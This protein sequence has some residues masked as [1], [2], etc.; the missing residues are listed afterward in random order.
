MTRIAG[1]PQQ[2]EMFSSTLAEVGVELSVAAVSV[3][4]AG[5]PAM[6]PGVAGQVIE[7]L[8]HTGTALQRAAVTAEREAAEVRRRALW[9]LAADRGSTTALDAAFALRAGEMP[10]NVL[11]LLARRRVTQMLA[12]WG[13][14]TRVVLPVVREYGPTSMPATSIWFSWQG[15]NPMPLSRLNSV[16]RGAGDAAS[17]ERASG[18]PLVGLRAVAGKV[19]GPLG[20]A[21]S[22]YS[23]AY[24]EH[25]TGWERTGDQ[26]AAGAGMLGSGGMTALA[27]A[28]E[29][30]AVPGVNIA[31]G[32]LLVGA[33][34]WEIYTHRKA[35]A[36]AA[37]SAADFAWKHRTAVLA[38]TPAGPAL[39]AWDHR[40]DI[41][42]G[43]VAATKW[44]GDRLSDVGHG[45]ASAPGEIAHDFESVTNGIHF[46]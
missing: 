36:H 30:A 13:R 10:L 31:V 27:F 14:Y 15:R 25:S 44:S 12:A 22:I 19:L 46:P 38:G 1:I 42:R 9:L 43:A 8:A 26:V 24:P 39:V 16:I 33:A 37:V 29:L 11:D 41:A 18:L 3:S 6:P 45:I 20:V 34:G 28:P 2:L 5:V 4:E 23:L 40:K 7:A 32:A 17:Y 35:I 21:T